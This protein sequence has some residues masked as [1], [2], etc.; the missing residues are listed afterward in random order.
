MRKKGGVGL[1][2]SSDRVL[3]GKAA[4]RSEERKRRSARRRDSQRAL[5][6]RGERRGRTAEQKLEAAV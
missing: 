2:D 3:A 5:R 6:S 1:V 4:A